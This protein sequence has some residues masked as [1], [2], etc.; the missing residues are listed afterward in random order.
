[1]ICLILKACIYQNI[2]QAIQGYVWEVF[3]ILIW[4]EWRK[5]QNEFVSALFCSTRVF[6]NLTPD[7]SGCLGVITSILTLPRSPPFHCS[8]FS[9][10]IHSKV[11]QCVG[12]TNVSTR[13]RPSKCR[14]YW[15]GRRE[16]E[17]GQPLMLASSPSD[18]RGRWDSLSSGSWVSHD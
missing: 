3:K 18:G 12:D 15:E 2:N 6:R 4:P 13:C 11:C 8:N 17:V 10:I 1:M 7:D 16:V 9:I 14:L 5:V